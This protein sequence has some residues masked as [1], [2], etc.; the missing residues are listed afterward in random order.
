MI[1]LKIRVLLIF[2]SLLFSTNIWALKWDFT[3]LE[4]YLDKYENE[5]FD[6]DQSESHRILIESV[7]SMKKCF[8]KTAEPRA[9]PR[10]KLEIYK[11][12]KHTPKQ[13]VITLSNVIDNIDVHHLE[14]LTKCIKEILPGHYEAR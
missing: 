6:T 2:I 9:H 3:N 4:N 13:P 5:I 14:V 1:F 7:R 12:V 8:V 11:N 10:D